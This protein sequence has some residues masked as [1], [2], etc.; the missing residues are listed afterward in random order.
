VAS[1]VKFRYN[2]A[3]AIAGLVVLISAV[4]LASARWYLLWILLVPAAIAVYA[5]RAGTDA[6]RSAVVVRALFGS[7]RFEWSRVTGLVP[8]GRGRVHAVLDDGASIRLPAVTTADLPRLVAAT[9]QELQ[10]EQAQ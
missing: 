10:G 8:D 4:P 1:T 3:V 6:D 7:R 2:A 5:W 9:G